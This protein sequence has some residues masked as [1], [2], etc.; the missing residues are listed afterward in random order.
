MYTFYI[1]NVGI[2]TIV[3]ISLTLVTTIINVFIII[4]MALT[5][6]SIT[7]ERKVSASKGDPSFTFSVNIF[8]IFGDSNY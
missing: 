8:F 5:V 4:I 7:E 2:S 6:A 3:N 1:L